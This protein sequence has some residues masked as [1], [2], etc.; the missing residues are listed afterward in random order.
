MENLRPPATPTQT[1]ATA[2]AQGPRRSGAAGG[3]ASE[4]SAQPADAFMAL[5][6]AIDQQ[7]DALALPPVD[8][9]VSV[10]DGVEDASLGASGDAST[11]PL[12]IAQGAFDA[13]GLPSGAAPAG[14]DA[15][16]SLLA[17]LTAGIAGG[18]LNGLVA[19]TAQ[20][21]RAAERWEASA[22]SVGARRGGA[23]GLRSAVA[24]AASRALGA[25]ADSP[26]ATAGQPGGSP[27]AA[28][29][30][31]ES[32]HP[33]VAGLPHALSAVAGIVT[34]ERSGQSVAAAGAEALRAVAETLQT[35]AS[36]DT[37]G[38]PAANTAASVALPVRAEAPAYDRAASAAQ[39]G[40][41]ADVA[42]MSSPQAQ[43]ADAAAVAQADGLAARI[44]Q[45]EEQLSE[46]LAFWVNQHT[47]SAE[48]TVDQNGLPVEVRV[49]LQ[50][51]E[52]HVSF[53]SDQE[54]TRQALDERVAQLRELLQQQGLQ[55]AGVTVGSTLSEGASGRRGSS[56]ESNGRRTVARIQV[57]AAAADQVPVARGTG[58]QSHRALD[59]FA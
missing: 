35:T 46:Q 6:A 22:S 20:M 41:V 12:W 24:A 17:G 37:A 45:M 18:L 25:T 48:M 27:G 21:D 28:R 56:E 39:A 1:A 59:V 31:G 40:G 33:L 44:T 47:Q 36:N 19:Q 52:A 5:L 57:P 16:G 58:T 49:S 53:R 2:A 14:A 30:G 32:P 55:L 7:A 26:G 15:D 9:A 8:A 11:V 23:G 54:Q 10:A 38:P 13:S 29:S 34:G 3:A 43:Q 4:A 42:S 50:G 51:N